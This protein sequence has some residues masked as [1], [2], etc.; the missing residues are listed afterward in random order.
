MFFNHERSR[1][2]AL[3]CEKTMTDTLLAGDLSLAET[4][5]F[6]LQT[7]DTSEAALAPELNVEAAA[8]QAPN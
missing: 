8:D 6:D 3:A 4:S 2:L 7:L 1:L 5:S